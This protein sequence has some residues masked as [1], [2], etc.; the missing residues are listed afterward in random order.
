L[1]NGVNV[2]IGQNS[3]NFPGTALQIAT[4]SNVMVSGS[5]LQGVTSAWNWDLAGVVGRSGCMG[6]TGAPGSQT[7]TRLADI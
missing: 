6:A 4:S 2:E 1:I 7:F 5:I 3:G